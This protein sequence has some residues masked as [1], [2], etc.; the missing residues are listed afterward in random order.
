MAAL[1]ESKAGISIVSKGKH[2]YED[3]ECQKR[4]N[5]CIL[6]RRQARIAQAD[7]R[8]EMAVDEDFYDGIQYTEADLAVFRERGQPPVTYNKVKD[9][10]NFILGTE[11]KSK[12]D[13]TVLPR[14]KAGASAAKA[15]TKVMKFV[16]DVNKGEFARSEA[17][18]DSAVAGVGWVESGARNTD[19]IL[20]LR[21]ES[22]RNV[23]YDHLGYSPVG[24]DWRFVL[25]EKWIDV[26]IATTMFEDRKDELETLAESVNS[27][28]PYH[29][30]DIVMTD[31]ASAFDLESGLDSFYSGSIETARPRIKLMEMQYRTPQAVKILKARANDTPYGALDGAIYRSE[32]EDHKYLV[33]GRYFTTIDA[34]RLVTRHMLWAGRTVLQEIQSPYN[35]N[36]F[37]LIPIFCY[38]RKRNNAPYGIVRD[39]RDPQSDLNRRR[40]KSYWL[41]SVN[42]YV[43][44][45]GAVP[46][47]AEFHTEMNKADGIAEVNDMQGWRK[48]DHSPEAA[49]HNAVAQDDERFIHSISGISNDTEWQKRKELSGKAL[50]TMED[51]SSTSNAVIFDRYWE[52]MQLTG[53]I[54]LSNVEQFYDQ[55]KELRITGDQQQQEFITVNERKPDGSVDN[56]LTATKADFI[57]GKQAYRETIRKAMMQQFLDILGIISKAGGAKGVEIT[58]SLLDILVDLMDDLPN[59]DEALARIRKITGQ[60][61]PEDEMTDQE[62]TQVKQ[63][64]QQAM[65]DK[66]MM[67]QMQEALMQARV[68]TEQAKAAKSQSEI[69]KNVADAILKKMDSFIKAME[70]AGEVGT[71]PALVGAADGII[72]EASNIGGNGQTQDKNI[73]QSQGGMPQ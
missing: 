9:T 3:E 18:Q 15:K 64:E 32:W 28:Y 38:R 12:I 22:W 24:N 36:R 17:F 62:K 66:A 19:D 2:P 31:P 68:A 57:I 48:V 6:Y 46:D 26:D 49:A 58:I 60:H 51:Q 44:K 45:T 30:D 20:F 73:N 35:H 63:A 47:K 4:L 25:R 11:R 33:Q 56:A 14:K 41:M 67:K 8:M 5:K 16:N 27:L 59:K 65:R 21:P 1:N 29:P 40:S 37:T 50:D 52:A 42:Q 70:V 69:M 43:I 54:I 10:I 53:E 13:W 39:I 7:N 72:A 23:W 61:A 55:E 34:I 71:K